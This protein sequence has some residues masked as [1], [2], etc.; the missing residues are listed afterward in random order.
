M[1][2][3]DVITFPVQTRTASALTEITVVGA[4][5]NVDVTVVLQ[6]TVSHLVTKIVQ[7]A[8]RCFWVRCRYARRPPEEEA[9]ERSC[10]SS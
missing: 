5:D 10:L 9:E 2:S 7:F 8:V 6:S 3:G 4:P 1:L